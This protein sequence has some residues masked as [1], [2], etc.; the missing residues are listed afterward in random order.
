MI[1]GGLKSQILQQAELKLTPE[2]HQME[3]CKYYPNVQSSSVSLANCELANRLKTRKIYTGNKELRNIIVYT[4]S[5]VTWLACENEKL[6][7]TL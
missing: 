2:A 6:L 5:K 3:I 1:H 7:L 4:V